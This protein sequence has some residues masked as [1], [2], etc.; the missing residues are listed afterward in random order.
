L[1]YGLLPPGGRKKDMDAVEEEGEWALAM[2]LFNW[3][4]SA[5]S[6]EEM[7]SWRDS[8]R[9]CGKNQ[10]QM[11]LD[12]WGIRGTELGA[13][14][15]QRVDRISFTFF[16]S[17]HI[18]SVQNLYAR[19]PRNQTKYDLSN[20]LLQMQTSRQSKRKLQNPVPVPFSY[21]D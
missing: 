18:Y 2:V 17:S 14:E 8:A 5:E 19:F 6:V 7:V 4:Q 13:N 10:V 16:I 21:I 12:P 11:Q 15:A 20:P 3:R 1:W 9:S